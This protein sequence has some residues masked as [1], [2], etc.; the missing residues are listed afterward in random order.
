MKKVAAL[1]VCIL[2]FSSVSVTYSQVVRKPDLVVTKIDVVLDMGNNTTTVKANIWN[3]GNAGTRSGFDVRITVT[4]QAV[5]RGPVNSSQDVWCHALQAKGACMAIAVF[6][7]TDWW[8]YYAN[9]DVYDVVDESK[10]KNN[11]SAWCAW[12]E[13]VNFG[14]TFVT[15]LYVGNVATYPANIDLVVESVSP[16]MTVTLEPTTVCVG[17]EE[18]TQVVMTVEFEPGFTGG[19]VVIVGIYDDG[20]TE[21][22]AT[23]D[24]VGST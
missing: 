12:V 19:Q 9:A 11:T 6:N 3:Q 13:V 18:I 15:D 20:Y 24:F 10:E 23:I 2:V 21:S 14:E 1:V 17:I 7:G 4:N 22:P 16:G 8:N 5:G